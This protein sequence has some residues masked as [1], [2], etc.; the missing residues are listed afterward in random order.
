MYYRTR[1]TPFHLSLLIYVLLFCL[2]CKK[3]TDEYIIP[4][5]APINENAIQVNLQFDRPGDQINE[6]FLGLG[7]E[8][9][10]ITIPNYFT[11]DRDILI[12]LFKNLGPAVI[13]M[14]A[15]SVDKTFWTGK[16]R[17]IST[18]SDSI[19]TTDID[20]F[21]EF[22]QK[23]GNWQVIFGL[24]LGINN[25]E[26]ATNEA[27]YV[28][29][30]LGSKLLNFELGNEPEVYLTNGIRTPAYSYTDYKNESEAYF[31]SIRSL[32]P[33][34]PFSGPGIVTEASWFKSF[35]K[36]AKNYINMLTAH[37][38]HMGPATSSAMNIDRLLSDLYW[39]TRNIRVW[40][41]IAA[42]YDIPY[43]VSECNSVYGGG[44]KG[45]SNV[46]A[47]ALWAA[48]MMWTLANNNC[49]GVNFHVGYNADDWYTPFIEENGQITARPLY[50]GMLFFKA[51]SNG[52]IIPLDLDAK[53][54]K[55]NA[56]ACQSNDGT[57]YVSVINKEAATG[58]S[59]Q[60]HTGN[61]ISSGMIQRLKA[62]SLSSTEEITF[63]GAVVNANGTFRP[64][65]SEN[66]IITGS[67]LE[68]NLPAASALIAIIK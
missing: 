53:G 41:N 22:L 38:Y 47:S 34:A 62:P 10:D 68:V 17:Q 16:E 46:F 21:D 65:H 42:S 40:K 48:D 4:P 54:L 26:I 28:Y 11:P 59:I 49:H 31:S 7:Y 35:A 19:T 51:G 14:G 6:H 13:R 64:Q 29:K 56:Y 20:R 50:Y 5:P 52:R 9:A 66:G 1:L 37:H 63:A 57:T 25:P 60:I 58:A 43:R 39:L 36:D 67:T 15:Q 32:L 33:N 61:R 12:N 24:N 18:P 2:G 55:V 45:V 8:I 23:V 27:E 30:K 44:R 3:S